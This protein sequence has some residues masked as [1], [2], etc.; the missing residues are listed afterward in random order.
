MRQSGN[1]LNPGGFTKREPDFAGF[2]SLTFGSSFF[3]SSFG[4]QCGRFCFPIHAATQKT[5]SLLDVWGGV[6][7]AEKEGDEANTDPPVAGGETAQSSRRSY[8]KTLD[9]KRHV[10]RTNGRQSDETRT[11]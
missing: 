11:G 2:R 8:P 9:E 1:G 3:G 10:C 5:T 7:L 6:R 4:C